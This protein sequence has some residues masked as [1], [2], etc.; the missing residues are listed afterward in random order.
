MAAT[1]ALLLLSLRYAWQ[2]FLAVTVR[3]PT[4]HLQARRLSKPEP[5]FKPLCAA[6]MSAWAAH[7]SLQR[8]CRSKAWSPCTPLLLQLQVM[9]SEHVQARRCCRLTNN[10]ASMRPLVVQHVYRFRK[11]SLHGCRSIA[12]MGQVR[13]DVALTASMQWLPTANPSQAQHN[14]HQKS[15]FG[16]LPSADLDCTCR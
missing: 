12:Q 8:R 4:S 2:D 15:A 16:M 13:K 7:W 1:S 11:A 5:D 3:L 10:S 9:P 14:L 6:E